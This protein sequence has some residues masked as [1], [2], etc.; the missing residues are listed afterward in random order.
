[1]QL[2]LIHQPSCNSVDVDVFGSSTAKVLLSELDTGSL[3]FDR[4]RTA[5]GPER[6]SDSLGPWNG[7]RLQTGIK[8]TTKAS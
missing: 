2:R 8:A 1:M 3:V 7:T 5:L 6:I 4:F